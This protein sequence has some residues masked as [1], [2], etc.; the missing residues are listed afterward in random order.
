MVCHTTRQLLL[1]IKV[2]NSSAQFSLGRVRGCQQWQSAGIRPAARPHL[3]FAQGGPELPPAGAEPSPGPRW[4][5]VRPCSATAPRTPADGPA[6]R[7]GGPRGPPLTPPRALTP[8]RLVPARRAT[9]SPSLASG[10]GPGGPESRRGWGL[11]GDAG[12]LAADPGSLECAF[13]QWGRRCQR[14]RVTSAPSVRTGRRRRRTR[15]ATPRPRARRADLRKAARTLGRE[16]GRTGPLILRPAPSRQGPGK[17]G[18]P[19][20][21]PGSSAPV[22]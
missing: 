21:R 10:A 9:V 5:R 17:R 4:A 18:G 8:R 20:P 19:C 2:C 11:R 6:R 1:P 7:H 12:A 13:V 15:P 3:A 16:E 14:R 22:S